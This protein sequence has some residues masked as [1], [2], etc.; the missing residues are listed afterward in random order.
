MLRS[1]DWTKQA[2]VAI[3]WRF[4]TKKISNFNYEELCLH[5]GGFFSCIS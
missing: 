1:H 5:G 2:A 3:S 4:S